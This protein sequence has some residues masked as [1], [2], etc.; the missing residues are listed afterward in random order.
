[1]NKVRW[2]WKL[3]FGRFCLSLDRYSLFWIR[4]CSES[5]KGLTFL[6]NCSDFLRPPT[7]FRFGPAFFITKIGASLHLRLLCH[8]QDLI[9]RLFVSLRT[10]PLGRLLSESMPGDF[11]EFLTLK[12]KEERGPCLFTG[13]GHHLEI[14]G[15]SLV[16]GRR[17][18]SDKPRALQIPQDV[19]WVVRSPRWRKRSKNF[20]SPG[21]SLAS[22]GRLL[23]FFLFL[24]Y[25]HVK[26]YISLFYEI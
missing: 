10:L 17:L 19:S 11:M 3:A 13:P 21:L 1:M 12:E 24:N 14:Y 23:G 18:S 4:R 25:L 16:V 8:P 5:L 22:Q 6:R 7:L 26:L 9:W 15:L 20:K 2:C